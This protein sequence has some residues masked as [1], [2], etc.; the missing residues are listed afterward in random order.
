[1]LRDST[2]N[3]M[4]KMSNDSHLNVVH[5]AERIEDIPRCRHGDAK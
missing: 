2:A 1:M 5:L 4:V 3:I